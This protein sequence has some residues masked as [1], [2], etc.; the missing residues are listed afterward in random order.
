MPTDSGG[1]LDVPDPVRWTY[2]KLFQ[3]VRLL[4][5]L[6]LDGL[7]SFVNLFESLL[8]GGLILSGFIGIVNQDKPAAALTIADNHFLY[9][10][11]LPDGGKS[12]PLGQNLLVDLLVITKFL[13]Y[14]VMTA[15]LLKDQAILF[16]THSAQGLWI[17]GPWWY[18]KA[19]QSVPKTGL[20]L[21]QRSIGKHYPF[22]TDGLSN[23]IIDIYATMLR[24]NNLRTT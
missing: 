23:I 4:S 17:L 22:Q 18:Q 20:T 19:D 13:S 3:Y 5:L 1:H 15:S 24:R 9:L 16:R 21:Q 11:I 6:F 7:K 2:F 14:D 10:Q 12:S 8:T